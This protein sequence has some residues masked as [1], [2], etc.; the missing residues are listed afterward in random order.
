MP[1]NRIVRRRSVHL[2]GL[3]RLAQVA[4]PRA[5]IRRRPEPQGVDGPGALDGLG[6]GAVERRVRRRLALVGRRRALEVPAHDQQQRARRRTSRSRPPARARG[7]RTIVS[8]MRHD[9]DDH[10]RDA[11]AHRVLELVDV[12]RR[13][14]HEVA[15]A[16]PLD[17]G[18]RQGRDRLDELLAQLGE[19]LL[20]EH[21]RRALR[22][23]DEHGL[24]EH[25]D[26]ADGDQRVDV[27]RRGA[28]GDGVDE[29][30]QQPRPGQPGDRGQRVQRR[31]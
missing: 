20:A 25:G 15:R 3:E 31:R 6:D 29:H 19:H 9:G 23:P 22:E 17:D 21:H 1:G 27:R 8:E 24:R 18:Q 5:P 26:G 11:E 7:T 13:A 30:A 12:V 16:G 10:A 2:L 14:R 28:A 4:R